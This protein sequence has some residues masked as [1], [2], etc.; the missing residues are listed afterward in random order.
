LKPTGNTIILF[1][2]FGHQSKKKKKMIQG[3]LDRADSPTTTTT[4]KKI[5]NIFAKREI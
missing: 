4:T 5:G 3:R 2:F 1:K